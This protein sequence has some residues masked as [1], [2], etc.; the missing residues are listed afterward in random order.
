M[1]KLIDQRYELDCYAL[2]DAREKS[3]LSRSEFAYACNW[4]Y[5][6]QW[7]LETGSYATV[8]ESTKNVIDDVLKRKDQ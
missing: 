6:Y 2:A 3:G 5:Q 4:S 8:S 1:F 7:K